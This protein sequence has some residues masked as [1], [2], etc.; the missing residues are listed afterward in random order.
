MGFNSAFKGLN[1]T[2]TERNK[3]V[4]IKDKTNTVNYSNRE[5]VRHGVPQGSIL[6]PL[7]FLIIYK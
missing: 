4:A 1:L 2:F 7:F 5:L 3:K 6:G